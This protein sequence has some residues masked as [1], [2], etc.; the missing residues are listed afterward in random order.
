MVFCTLGQGKSIIFY[1]E[2]QRRLR[3]YFLGNVYES[4]V[5]REASVSFIILIDVSFQ[6]YAL[7]GYDDLMMFYIFF[8]NI[9]K[10]CKRTEFT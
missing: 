7:F 9:T 4:W 5:T 2:S 3:N 6:P 10:L 1:P 8:L